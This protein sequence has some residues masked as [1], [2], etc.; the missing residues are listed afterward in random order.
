MAGGLT[1]L[2]MA[3]ANLL[4]KGVSKNLVNYNVPDHAAIAMIRANVFAFSHAKSLVQMKA[5]TNLVVDKERIRS[6]Q[7]FEK[8]AAKIGTRYNRNYLE[9]EYQ[10]VVASGQMGRRYMEV[11]ADKDV[12]PLLRWDAINDERTRKEH[13]RMDGITRP[14]DDPFWKSYWPPLGYRCRCDVRQ[15]RSGKVTPKANAY[16]KAKQTVNNKSPFIG[17]IAA[18]GEVFSTNHSYFGGQKAFDLKP[19]QY[20]LRPLDKIYSKGGLPTIKQGFNNQQEWKDHFA[21]LYIKH[22]G[23]DGRITITD[24]LDRPVQIDVDVIGTKH[25]KSRYHLGGSLLDVL[26]NPDE[27]YSNYHK[28]AR[29]AKKLFGYKYIKYYDGKPVVAV[30]KPEGDQLKAQTIYDVDVSQAGKDRKGI[31]HYVDRY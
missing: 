26:Q 7:D 4:F 13:K 24:K 29:D 12:F 27:V 3:T 1:Q 8:E 10:T 19:N 15:V 9:A 18:Q 31:L 2:T 17:N 21:K 6:F 14:A 20:G 22:G 28:G 23:K 16:A 25:S 11:R 30:V 5:L